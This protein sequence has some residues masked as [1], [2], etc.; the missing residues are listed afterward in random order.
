VKEYTLLK[1]KI[2]EQDKF[3]AVMVMLVPRVV[4]LIMEREA[5]S[6]REAIELFYASELYERLETEETKLWHLS[7]LTLY[8]LFYEELTTG[9]IT[10]PEEA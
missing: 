4:A 8:D 10:Y 1:E 9:K 2:M 5:I 6:A 3:A 7:A